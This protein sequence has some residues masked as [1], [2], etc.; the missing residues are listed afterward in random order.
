MPNF[1]KN[2]WRAITHFFH[3]EGI[4]PTE[5]ANSLHRHYGDSSPDR[6]TVSRWMAHFA[7]GREVLEDDP[8]VGGPVTVTM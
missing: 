2:E 7:A 5:A 3:K 6:S 8:R 1:A 4:T